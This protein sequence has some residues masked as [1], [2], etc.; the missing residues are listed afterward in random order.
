MNVTAVRCDRVVFNY[1]MVFI[2]HPVYLSHL[3][4][5][6]KETMHSCRSVHLESLL[7]FEFVQMDIL[8]TQPTMSSQCICIPAT[9]CKCQMVSIFRWVSHTRYMCLMRIRGY[10]YIPLSIYVQEEMVFSKECRLSQVIAG[11]LFAQRCCYH[12]QG[13]VIVEISDAGV[14]YMVY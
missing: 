7:P 2:H 11:T 4:V 6:C 9:L 10:L 5:N 13:R 8:I 1:Q 14:Q 12:E 3:P